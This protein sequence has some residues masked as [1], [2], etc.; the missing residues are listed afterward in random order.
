MILSL[1]LFW[2]LYAKNYVQKYI[3]FEYGHDIKETKSNSNLIIEMLN[4]EPEG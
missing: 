4:D 2:E 1:I 3:D